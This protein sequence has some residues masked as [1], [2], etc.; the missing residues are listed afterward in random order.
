MGTAPIRKG[1]HQVYW[2]EVFWRGTLFA[3]FVQIRAKGPKK[4]NYP[5]YPSIVSYT[6]SPVTSNNREPT[7]NNT[8]SNPKSVTEIRI[9]ARPL[10][11]T[12]SSYKLWAYGELHTNYSHWLGMSQITLPSKR[13][14]AVACSETVSEVQKIQH[15][16]VTAAPSAPSVTTLTPAAKKMISGLALQHIHETVVQASLYF[17]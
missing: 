12:V 14:T 8:K 17:S 6:L 2:K 4:H 10:W 13:K 3:H 5:V 1:F 11:E 7:G 16:V 15:G 9:Q